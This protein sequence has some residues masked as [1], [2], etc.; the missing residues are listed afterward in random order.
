[1]N[2][3]KVWPLLASLLYVNLKSGF[4]FDTFG[5]PEDKC[6][7]IKDNLVIIRG[8]LDDFQTGG[9]NINHGQFEATNMKYDFIR[10]MQCHS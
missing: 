2:D 1:M 4:S 6:G 3:P 8:K 10:Q 9:G 5:V 7:H